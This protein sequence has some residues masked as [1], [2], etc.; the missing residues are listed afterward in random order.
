ML[1]A[2]GSEH[3]ILLSLFIMPHRF[4]AKN[5]SAFSV[6]A[7]RN[8]HQSSSEHD[9]R[10]HHHHHR[11]HPKVKKQ[12]RVKVLF[13][14]RRKSSAHPNYANLE[15]VGIYGMIVLGTASF[16]VS[17]DVAIR[18]NESVQSDSRLEEGREHQK[19]QRQLKWK[20]IGL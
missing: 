15:F 20:F 8:H 10:H 7:R 1:P 11:D 3:R 16:R 5:G 9:H 6:V 12:V 19:W 18:H 13:R 17:S 4:T 2:D 14:A